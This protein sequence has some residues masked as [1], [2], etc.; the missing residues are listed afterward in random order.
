MKKLLS[1]LGAVGL[2]ATGAS[3]AV[4]CSNTTDPGDKVILALGDITI[5]G[6]PIREQYK[7]DAKN[8]EGKTNAA[9]ILDA[10]K[11]KNKDLTVSEQATVEGITLKGAKI[12]DGE[13]V[14]NVTYKGTEENTNP[15]VTKVDLS[16]IELT[17]FVAK[18]DTE[19]LAVIAELVKVE[20]LSG[21]KA[22]DVTITKV[23]ATNEAT[24][25]I[26]IKA[27]D[28]SELVE[29]QLVLTIAQLAE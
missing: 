5:A 17:D 9:V 2:T 28:S 13:T 18:N 24:G 1:I 16:K 11:A 7:A 4:S 25:T 21:L 19:D 10:F 6:T 23:D 29:G 14:Y 12:K 8:K 27:N 20:G 22:E 26:T 15:E 3:V